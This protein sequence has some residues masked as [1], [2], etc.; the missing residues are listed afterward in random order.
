[1]R[2]KRSIERFIAPL[3]GSAPTRAIH[4][5]RPAAQGDS[6]DDGVKSGDV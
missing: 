2:C 3:A 4:A 5:R 1:M 6:N